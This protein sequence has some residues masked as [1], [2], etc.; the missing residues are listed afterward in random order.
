[1]EKELI[2]ASEKAREDGKAYPRER[3]AM[4]ELTRR[5]DEP[6]ALALI[7][8]RGCGKT[9]LLKQLHARAKSSFYISLDAQPVSGGL[10]ALAKELA[11]QG[12]RYLLADEIHAQP[13]FE[14]DLKKIYDFGGL[15]VIF[16]SSSALALHESAYDLSRRVRLLPIRPF[17]MRE[18]AEFAKN[19]KLP[20]ISWEHWLDE[21][22]AREYYGKTLHMEAEFER[23]VG[24]AAYPFSL[25]E[26]DAMPLLKQIRQTI[27]HN[28][29]PKHAHLMPEEIAEAENLLKFIGRAAVE[30]INYSS[31]AQNAGISKYKAQKYVDLLERAFVLQRVWPAGTNVMREPKIL[32]ALSFR[33]LYRQME[34]CIGGL[35]EDFFISEMTRLGRETHYLKSLRGEKTPDYEVE[36]T[37]IEIGG[38]SKSL[39]QF[40]G[41]SAGRKL[42]LTHPGRLDFERRPLFM[43]SMIA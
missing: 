10:F 15:K 35:R 21:K 39:R 19:E 12:V 30:D 32:M 27:L 43:T 16:T 23:F 38:V 3:E 4:A 29:L 1:M 8:P 41:F 26:P 13:N 42:I 36:G 18:W 40:K 5:M 2:E 24:G 25:R 14:G 9:I 31:I 28:D 6:S 34:D 17:S 37:V 22:T 11:E 7:G 20:A 33:L